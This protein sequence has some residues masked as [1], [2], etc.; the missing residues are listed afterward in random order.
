MLL[1]KEK[2]KQSK[3]DVFENI[4]NLVFLI[5]TVMGAATSIF[6]NFVNRSLWLDEAALA[7]SFS[8][9]SF[10]NLWNGSLSNVQSAP[11]GWLYFEKIL[12]VIFG[13]TE[14]VVRIGSILGF[15]LT[16]LL[17][18]YLLRYCF[19][20]KYPLGACA[21]YANM[22]FILKYSNVFKPY[23]W[24]GFFVL[25][26]IL[27]F[28]LY[29]SEKINY[30]GLAFGWAVLIWFSNP[31]CFFEGGLLLSE[32][33][34]VLRG[35]RLNSQV[36]Y[37]GVWDR[38]KKAL[39]SLKEVIVTGVV[40]LSGFIVYYFFWLREVAVSDAMQ[41]YWAGK[42]FPLIPTSLDD[43]VK[44]K[45]MITGIF[46]H[47]GVCRNLFLL[48]MIAG[49]AV[50]V[51][52]KSRIL[53]GCYI[54]IFITCFAS[55]INMFPVQDRLWCFFYSVIV[56]L[57]FVGFDA[58]LELKL[59]KG[60]KVWG[61]AAGVLILL[62][63]LSNNGIKT[64]L[65]RENVYWKGEELNNEIEYLQEHIKEDEKVYV[66]IG[67]I[68]GFQYKNGYDNNS[69]GGYE[70]NVIW[71]ATPFT[72]GLDCKGEL[73]KIIHNK[74][75]IAASHYLKERDLSELLKGVYENGYFQLVSFEHETPLFFYCNDLR[76]SKVH[77]SYEV[78]ES[79]ENGDTVSMIV[80]IHNDGEAYLNHNWETVR[81]VNCENN[82]RFEMEK[83]VVPG[84]STDILISYEKG[85]NPL[86]CLKNEYGLICED[87][88]FCPETGEQ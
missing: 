28:H 76:D 87:S 62:M 40:I 57:G 78:A 47:I 88:E 27:L 7:Y 68:N 17:L 10:W 12:A 38:I 84:Q 54:G 75:Y 25:L 41:D 11:L 13:N 55:Y 32:A 43:L 26:V 45:G 61:Y 18:W 67:S 16:M 82:S 63:V 34:F 59:L 30:K 23:I 58:L 72:E 44:M 22:P 71:G 35:S 79:S 39:K 46:R 21:F 37:G 74:T 24:D 85:S 36:V 6:M 49:F 64:Y 5:T 3:Q 48:C 69:I 65:D 33:L 80:R 66:Y 29:K 4:L 31:V 19:R 2:S 56:L 15:V 83:N 50:A 73:E 51:I 53:I 14:F 81:L 60:N 86:F 8:T 1:N 42:N 9:R 20:I 70:N 77:V 52:R